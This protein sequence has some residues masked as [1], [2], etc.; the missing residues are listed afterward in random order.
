[1]VELATRQLSPTAARTKGFV[2]ARS[3][4]LVG[5]MGAGKTK[6]G[7]RLATRLDLP[8]ADSDSE[9]EAA[10]E[11]HATAFPGELVVGLGSVD[12]FLREIEDQVVV[13][14]DG[15]V[16]HATVVAAVLGEEGFSAVAAGEQA[17][18]G[19]EDSA[20]DAFF[21]FGF[22]AGG[23]IAVDV[24]VAPEEQGDVV[25]V[26]PADDAQAADVVVAE[27]DDGFDVVLFEPADDS[28]AFAPLGG[29][30]AD[31]ILA[32]DGF[33]S[34][35]SSSVRYSTTPGMEVSS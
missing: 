12:D 8:F 16:I 6:I 25:A 4:V 31:G 14:F 35:R 22:P 18:A 21:D 28:A 19:V 34:Y 32:K 23:A 26:T 20:D 30:V 27:H 33:G 11:D 2:P 10:A 9:I 15:V 13:G 7:R 17:G 3:I 29:D 24:A 1:M 5:L